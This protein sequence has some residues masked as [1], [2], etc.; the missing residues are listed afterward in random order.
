MCIQHVHILGITLFEDSMYIRYTVDFLFIFVNWKLQTI[1]VCKFGYF[2]FF[3]FVFY[4]ICEFIVEV[5]LNRDGTYEQ[6]CLFNTD[7]N[8]ITINE[9]FN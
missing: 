8:I 4:R 5:K 3:P 6:N 2:N 9:R 7:R 1:F